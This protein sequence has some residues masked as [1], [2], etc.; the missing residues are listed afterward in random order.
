[1]KMDRLRKRLND[2]KVPTE[3]IDFIESCLR[4]KETVEV[5]KEG[6]KVEDK[7]KSRISWEDVY[8]HPLFK[9][10]L[11]HVA[12]EVGGKNILLTIKTKAN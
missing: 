6:K 2:Q 4:E 9:G 10:E 12:R 1:M 3:I 7:Q 11:T 5:E 8:L